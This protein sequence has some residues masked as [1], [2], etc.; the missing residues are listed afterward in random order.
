[1]GEDKKQYDA[2]FVLTF[3]AADLEDAEDR[4][5]DLLEELY[6]KGYEPNGVATIEEAIELV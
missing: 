1:M 3:E 2:S 6:D 4:F 5:D